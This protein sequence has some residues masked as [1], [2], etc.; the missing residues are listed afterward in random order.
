MTYS[1]RFVTVAALFV[2]SLVTANI[3][4]VKLVEVGGHS[5]DAGTVIFPVSYILGDVLTEVYGFRAARRV[6]W[7][8]FFC[9]LVAV[10]AIL[11]AIQAPAAGFWSD[12]EAY[13]TILGY[14]P[15]ILLASFLAFLCGE[16]TNSIV[17]AKL[18]VRTEGRYLW[19]RTISSTVLG[20]AVDSTVFITV[21]FA[22]TATPLADTIFTIWAIKVGYEILATPITYAV[23]NWLK[24]TEGID[25]YDRDTRL[26]PVEL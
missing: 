21:A 24:R 9:N 16:F 25:V 18:K 20:Q 23:V 2:T 1:G 6:I 22:G 17:M 26:V 15:R 19:V 3:I 14:A 11:V 8:A 12:Q 10:I 7:T 5:F 13:E 4:A